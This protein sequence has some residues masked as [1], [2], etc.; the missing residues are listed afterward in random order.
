MWVLEIRLSFLGK[1]TLFWWPQGVVLRRTGGIPV[2]RRKPHDMVARLAQRFER[3]ERL[4]LVIPPEGT[5]ARSAHW[6]SGFFHIA[7]AARVP[8]V[9]VALD[10]GNRV[11]RFGEP[12]EVPE[13]PA[14]LMETLRAFFRGAR[15]RHPDRETPVRLRS[16]GEPAARRRPTRGES[17]RV[18]GTRTTATA[19][20]S[21]DLAAKSSAATGSAT[22][23]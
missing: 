8:V 5:R 22:E 15:G 6:K 17:T 21:P 12:L 23:E 4:I 9:A 19:T 18:D 1:H 11:L 16:E 3:S 7:R 14:A 10:W 13:D 20:E 2:N